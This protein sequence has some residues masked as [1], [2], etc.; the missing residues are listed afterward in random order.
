M[1]YI[2]TT[3]PLVRYRPQ[4]D[5]FW[6]AVDE[7]L[8]TD[9]RELVKQPICLKEIQDRLSRN[10]YMNEFEFANE[11]RLVLVNCQIY[12]GEFSELGV[13]ASELVK[14]FDIL[15]CDWILNTTP[16]DNLKPS[17]PEKKNAEVCTYIYMIR[18]P[19][20]CIIICFWECMC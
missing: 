5:I 17:E 13:I 20:C 2:H 4:C 11:C 14:S 15:F 19:Q 3:R 8:F 7:N 6:D 9:Y 1:L 18:C 16:V 10:Y 12:N